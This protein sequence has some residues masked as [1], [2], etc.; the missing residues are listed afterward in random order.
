MAEM[1]LRMVVDTSEAGI[2]KGTDKGGNGGGAGM[3]EGILGGMKKFAAAVGLA[4]AISSV[5]FVGDL[6]KI[7][8]GFIGIGI[9]KAL[10]GVA[11]LIKDQIDNFIESFDKT[12][13]ILK[14]AWDA[15]KEIAPEIWN[16]MKDLPGLIWEYLKEL[17]SKIWEFMKEVGMVIWEAMKQGFEWIKNIGADVWEFM[18]GV[19]VVI[20]DAI[21]EG[22]EWIKNIGADVWE[23]MKDLPKLIWDYV[24]QL[25]Q[26]I[27]NFMQQLPDLIAS[28]LS[29]ILNFGRRVS[30]GVSGVIGD[31]GNFFGIQD[32][33]ITKRGDVI[34]TDPNDMIF[35]TKNPGGM[36]SSRV[37]NFYGVT[38]QE[39]LDTIR[40]ELN[41]D[42]RVRSVF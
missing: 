15:I 20:W 13:E 9:L 23:F 11:A 14:A 25:P 1:K 24:K 3:Q 6:M 41:T 21:K 17:P 19:G 37:F 35:A 42:T 26:M 30:K 18:K 27:W 10:E 33:I 29:K 5:K 7:L 34:R 8:V 12:I 16:F 28:A 38:P 2:A 22:F 31:V 39:I 32:A 36:G 40:A 4:G